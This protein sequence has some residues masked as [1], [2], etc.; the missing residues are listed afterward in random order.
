MPSLPLSHVGRVSKKD[1]LA[2][3]A[4]AAPPATPSAEPFGAPGG[5]A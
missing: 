2:R 1:L 5:G 3:F 4:D